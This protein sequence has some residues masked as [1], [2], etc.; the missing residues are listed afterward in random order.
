MRNRRGNTSDDYYDMSINLLMASVYNAKDFS[1]SSS[2][3]SN[4]RHDSFLAAKLNTIHATRS[5]LSGQ[6]ST[7]EKVVIGFLVLC[8]VSSE[9]SV[10]VVI[11]NLA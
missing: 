2:L 3:A 5:K 7:F 10:E 4:A 6:P 9:V 8:L 11:L 1:T